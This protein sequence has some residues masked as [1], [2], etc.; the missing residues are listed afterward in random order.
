MQSN[1][2]QGDLDVLGAT[3]NGTE[4]NHESGTYSFS[5]AGQVLKLTCKNIVGAAAQKI[6]QVGSCAQSCKLEVQSKCNN[7]DAVINISI[8]T[9]NAI[10]EKSKESQVTRQIKVKKAD[11]VCEGAQ[12]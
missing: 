11:K 9:L 5:D 8:K 1:N 4:M 12:S 3:V 10:A 7:E 2:G 6:C